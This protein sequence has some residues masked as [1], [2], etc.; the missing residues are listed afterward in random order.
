MRFLTR[1]MSPL[2]RTALDEVPAPPKKP[3]VVG[4][5]DFSEVENLLAIAQF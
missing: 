3:S 2:Q 4:A 5:I 1:R